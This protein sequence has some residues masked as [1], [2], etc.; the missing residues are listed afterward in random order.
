MTMK[1]ELLA[2]VVRGL[3]AGLGCAGIVLA[4]EQ[5]GYRE[6]TAV[7]TALVLTAIGGWWY[8][9]HWDRRPLL[10]GLGTIERYRETYVE[11][12]HRGHHD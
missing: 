12:Q 11:R 8:A 2:G 3:I 5:A 10:D 6:R 9:K 1:R 4:L 7:T